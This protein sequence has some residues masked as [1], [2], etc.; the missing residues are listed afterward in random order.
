MEGA[1]PL[2]VTTAD[3]ALL[4]PRMV[5][6]FCDAAA[7][8]G[9]DLA[10]ALVAK[11]VVLAEV[12]ATKRTYLAF[13]DGRYSGANLFAF[14][15]PER[16][17]PPSDSGARWSRSASAPGSIAKAFGWGLSDRLPALRLL[18]LEQAVAKRR[19]SASGSRPWP[20][21]CPMAKLPSTSTSL[22]TWNWPKGS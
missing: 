10:A 2:L 7:A 13:R 15:T 20:C 6:S 21:R 9:A 8:G 3:H 12:P 1:H 16:P 18:S 11:P 14:M 4:A 19:R 5:R 17:V 22:P